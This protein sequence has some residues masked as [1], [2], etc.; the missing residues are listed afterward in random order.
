M[1]RERD[2]GQEGGYSHCSSPPL[3]VHAFQVS[4]SLVTSCRYAG[5]IAES[6]DDSNRHLCHHFH[7]VSAG[8]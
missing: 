3:L 8:F 5:G 2:Y 1:V 6:T 4:I 7:V